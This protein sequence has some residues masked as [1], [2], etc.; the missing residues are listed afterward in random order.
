[1]VCG[2]RSAV[3]RAVRRVGSRGEVGVRGMRRGVVESG[4]IGGGGLR[5][6]VTGELRD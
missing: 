5:S 2:V 4:A 3:W 6:L 1:M